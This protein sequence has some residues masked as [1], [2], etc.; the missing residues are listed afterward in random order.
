MQGL[1]HGLGKQQAVERVEMMG[2]N[3]SINNII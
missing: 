1:A 3:V 2:S